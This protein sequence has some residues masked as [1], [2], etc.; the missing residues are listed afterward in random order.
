MGWSALDAKIEGFA[1]V[2]LDDLTRSVFPERAADTDALFA[3][4]AVAHGSSKLLL[5]GAP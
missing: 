3:R 5:D 1:A 4:A 2:V